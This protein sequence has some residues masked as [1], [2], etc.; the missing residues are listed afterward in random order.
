MRRFT[1]R[2]NAEERARFAESVRILCFPARV[3]QL[4]SV[5]RHSGT[6]GFRVGIIASECSQDEKE[7]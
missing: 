1:D 6:E 2:A 4:G 5:R 3:A 7:K